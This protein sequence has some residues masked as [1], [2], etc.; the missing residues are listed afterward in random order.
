MNRISGLVIG[1]TLACG[2]C[3]TKC[4]SQ[5]RDRAEVGENDKWRLT[6][7]YT[8]D[9]AWR[10][11]KDELVSQFDKVTQFMTKSHL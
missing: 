10:K 5:T 6:D 2:L 7:I 1:V 11:A 8:S 3:Q 9:D 4:V